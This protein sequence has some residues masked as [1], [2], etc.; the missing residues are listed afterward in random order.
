M[1]DFIKLD[2]RYKQNNR[3]VYS[4]EGDKW[5]LIFNNHKE[6][7]YCRVGLKE[8]ETNWDCNDFSFV[9]PSG[10]PFISLNSKIDNKTVYK[11]SSEKIDGDTVYT[12]YM[13]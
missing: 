5:Y 13:K 8:G 7:D 2:N 3:L 4:G 11:I 1:S 12:I 6:Y 9:D 10:G